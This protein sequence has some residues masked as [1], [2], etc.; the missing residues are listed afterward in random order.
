[1]TLSLTRLFSI[2]LFLAIS[3]PILGQRSA[4]RITETNTEY[5]KER[6]PSLTVS[7]DAGVEAVYDPWQEFWEERYDID[8]DRTDKDRSS[9]AYLAE[10]VSLPNLSDKNLNLY[11][12][13]DGTD[14]IA[15]VS[16]SVVFGERD[17]VT[18]SSYPATHAAMKRILED[19]ETYFYRSY[20]DRQLA[21][22]KDELEE[23]RDDAED[24]EKDASKARS[25][26]DKYE[27]KIADLREKIEE[28]REE[29]AE[30]L[31]LADEKSTRVRELE[32]QL[33]EIEDRRREYV[34]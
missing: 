30:E 16:M 17:V 12:N 32:R 19:F 15:T 26:I 11:S 5:D 27:E 28:M 2:S 10:Q 33:R 20:F 31:Q 25:K 3:F 14:R 24:A 1:M 8:I 6:F 18:G 23:V 9:I 7:V 21:E 34:N 22:V 29:A 4:S 13:V